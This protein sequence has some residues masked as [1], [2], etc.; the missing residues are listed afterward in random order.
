MS[1]QYIE[2]HVKCPFYISIDGRTIKCEGPFK[3]SKACL[4]FKDDT[5]T[6][7]VLEK[8]CFDNYETCPQYIACNSKYK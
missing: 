1:S 7:N 8:Y 6:T 3:K 2:T 5:S 4:S